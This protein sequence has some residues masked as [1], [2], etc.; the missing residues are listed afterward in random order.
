M[1][2]IAMEIC[3]RNSV[4]SHENVG[5]FPVRYVTNY[6]RVS[7]GDIMGSLNFE[8]NYAKSGLFG[9]TVGMMLAIIYIHIL[10]IYIY[11][12]STL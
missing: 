7:H 3:H 10:Y 1:A 8:L 9:L 11:L 12:Y 6:Q 4:F 5:D 2:D